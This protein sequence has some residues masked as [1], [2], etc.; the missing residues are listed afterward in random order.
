MAQRI[1]N[2]YYTVAWIC[3]LP[4]ERTAASL[5]LEVSHEGPLETH[6][7]DKNNYQLGSIGQHN[8]VIAILPFGRYGTVNA[9]VVASHIKLTFPSIETY[10]M[11]GVGGGIPSTN[12][13]IR[14]GDIVV[15]KPEN[16]FGGVV[17]YDLG[18][19]LPGG[20]FQRSGALNKPPQMLLTAIASLK[21]KHDQGRS[22]IPDY[23]AKVFLENPDLAGE[24]AYQGSANDTLYKPEYTHE[25]GPTCESYRMEELVLRGD[26]SGSHPVIHYGIIAS[27]NQVIKDGITRDHIGVDVGA[28]CF[29]MEVAGLIDHFPC[30]AIRG[31]CDY[32]DSHKNKRWQ[33]YAALT[34]AAYAK[35]LLYQIAPSG[36]VSSVMGL[37]STG[38]CKRIF[39]IPRILHRHFSGR[40]TQLTQIYDFFHS[41]PGEQNGAIVSVFG[42]PGAGKSQ[43]CFK[44][45]VDHR[46]EYQYG[47]YAIASTTDQWLTSCNN[48][49]ESLGLPEAK[50]TEQP[51]RTR[52]LTRWLSANHSWILIIDDIRPSV[53][54]L[55]QETLSQFIGGHILLSTRDKHIA[56]EFSSPGNVIHLHEMD[57]KEGMELILEIYSGQENSVDPTVAEKISQELGGLPLALEQATTCAIKR[58]WEPETLLESLQEKK[59]ALLM[60]WSQTQDPLRNS[61]HADVIITLNMALKELDTAH[62]ALLNLIL[63]MRPQALPLSILVDGSSN[64]TY[65]TNTDGLVEH[66]NIAPN[67][68]Q[69]WAKRFRKR[70]GTLIKPKSKFK[71][72]FIENITSV[73][74]A[75][76]QIFQ[77]L[78]ATIQSQS[79]LHSAII[80][81]EKSSLLRRGLKGEIWVHDLFRKVLLGKLEE[82]ERQDLLWYAG[83]IISQ[84]FPY[85]S[86]ETR[87]KCSLYLIH[88]IEVIDCSYTSDLDQR[89]MI[90]G[91]DKIGLYYLTSGNYAKAVGWYQ[92]ALVTVEKY[93]DE[94]DQSLLWRTITNIGIALNRQGKYDD[95]VQWLDQG[96]ARCEKEMGEEHPW[97]LHFLR[98]LAT[99]F[100]NQG[101]F[102]DALR[103]QRRAVVGFEKILGNNHPKTLEAFGF[104]GELFRL[105]GDYAEATK[106]EK[107]V[108]EGY[109][110]I[111]GEDHPEI[112]INL[113]RQMVDAFFV[114]L[115]LD[116]ALEYNQEVLTRCEKY[117]GKDH[118]ST[119]PCVSVMAA[120]FSEQKKYDQAMEWHERALAGLERAL[121]TCH[122]SIFVIKHNIA[123]NFFHQDKYDEATQWYQDALVGKEEVLGM[124]HS[125]TLA[126]VYAIGKV[127]AAQKQYDQAK[128]FYEQALAG[129]VKIFGKDNEN[130]LR[131][132]RDLQRL[133]DIMKKPLQNGD[134]KQHE[135][136]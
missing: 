11:V 94:T 40:R 37:S 52:A 86:P 26:R 111:S 9:T 107:R 106:W 53:V 108:L 30:L 54:N 24:Y 131:V 88:A 93:L 132:E 66:K 73:E 14:L 135:I 39:D 36:T 117:F 67:A 95:A 22:N 136:F 13:D 5:I 29:E 57:P 120:I 125:S 46:K 119:F 103:L 123:S 76:L 62:V 1:P 64:L 32:S 100:G 44:Y 71:A 116:E 130:T 81:L 110:T 45:V 129:L 98:N 28:I 78:K 77:A 114:N 105:Q 124:N 63:V 102:V 72:P 23:L 61:H 43:L 97:T 31:I 82:W 2:R 41:K 49:I 91:N 65:K 19:T 18:K 74:P 69:D 25:S 17:Q 87:N 122:P 90:E 27:G 101:R 47:F 133:A 6:P 109:K 35:E 127:F 21:A 58:Y 15:S 70:L 79:K 42:I 7:G 89:E 20:H 75:R 55:L 56:S 83:R 48:I 4:V 38:E 34:A 84:V 10:L 59:Q 99:G 68:K 126:T 104:I 92:R 113:L 60:E 118:P 134:D 96:L 115:K 128:G 8:I 51:A 80:T 33:P 16:D 112:I 3:A 85:P 12:H 121:G 50:S